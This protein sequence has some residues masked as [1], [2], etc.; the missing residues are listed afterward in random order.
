MAKLPL[1]KEIL[2]RRITQH[3]LALL[4]SLLPTMMEIT[5]S[6]Y[7]ARSELLMVPLLNGSLAESMDC[8]R[9][10]NCLL[11]WWLLLR[12]DFGSPK[13]RKKKSNSELILVAV[14]DAWF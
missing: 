8:F 4:S 12:S 6:S 13:K 10:L 9:V 5:Y 11:W 1:L 3:F 2:T 7:S 14:S